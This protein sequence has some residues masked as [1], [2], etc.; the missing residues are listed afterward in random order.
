MTSPLG[1]IDGVGGGFVASVGEEEGDLGFL[2]TLKKKKVV[3][4]KKLVREARLDFNF[5]N[6]FM[7]I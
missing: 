6:R 1:L 5:L 4:K 2:S 3:V 7:E